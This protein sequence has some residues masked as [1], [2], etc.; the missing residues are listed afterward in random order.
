MFAGGVD[1]EIGS[2]VKTDEH[3]VDIWCGRKKIGSAS[4]DLLANVSRRGARA[5]SQFHQSGWGTQF[6]EHLSAELH[7]D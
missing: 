6:S 2:S 5:P 4:A 3:D 1:F 7:S